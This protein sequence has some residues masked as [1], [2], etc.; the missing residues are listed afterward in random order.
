MVNDPTYAKDI[1]NLA[2]RHLL[3][4]AYPV[5]TLSLKGIPW[6]CAENNITV[7]MPQNRIDNLKNIKTE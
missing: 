6:P 5:A 1:Q 4:L 7:P 3:G 2:V